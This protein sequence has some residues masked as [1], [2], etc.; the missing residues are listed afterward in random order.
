MKYG[1]GNKW[2]NFAPRFGFA[3]DP[4]G[5]GKSSIRGSYGIFYAT[6]ALQQKYF[7]LVRGESTD[8]AEWRT[9]VYLKN[10]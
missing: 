4:F 6:R 3:L 7:A 8:H 10:E 5:D 1:F 2:A 9:P